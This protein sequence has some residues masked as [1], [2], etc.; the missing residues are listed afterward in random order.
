MGRLSYEAKAEKARQSLIIT[1]TKIHDLEPTLG[2][3]WREGMLDYYTIRLAELVLYQLGFTNPS[4]LAVKTLS[5][6]ISA[7]LES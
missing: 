7:I 3:K 6:E 1:I 5:D 4:A 2:R